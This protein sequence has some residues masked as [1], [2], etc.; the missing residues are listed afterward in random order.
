MVQGGQVTLLFEAICGLDSFSIFAFS[1][2][3]QSEMTYT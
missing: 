1:Q 3:V 2:S